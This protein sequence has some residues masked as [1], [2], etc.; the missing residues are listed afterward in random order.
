MPYQVQTR[1][2]AAGGQGK[3]SVPGAWPAAL[4]AALSALLVAYWARQTP[5][6]SHVE[7]KAGVSSVAEVSPEDF[8]AALGTV[9]GTPR[10][11]ARLREREACRR[12]LALVT[13]RRE[14]GQAPG[15]IRLQSGSYYSPL[16]ELLET[17]VRIALPYPVPYE[18]GRGVISV[19]GATTAAVVALSPPWHVPAQAGMEARQVTW[20]PVGACPGADK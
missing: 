6:V 13:I 17:P 8:Q 12:R 11:L 7:D 16:F 3:A 14:P 2:T 18:N 9:A 10:Q 20:S 19:V 5:D 1:A 15:K 4:I